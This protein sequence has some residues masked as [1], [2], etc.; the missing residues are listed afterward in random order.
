M[1]HPS[2]LWCCWLQEVL[3][4]AR[5]AAA[6]KREVKKEEGNDA[7]ASGGGWTAGGSEDDSL[8]S[9]AAQLTARHEADANEQAKA[10]EAAGG[11]LQENLG[12]GSG[13]VHP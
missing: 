9:W 1:A 12:A 4:R 7:G 6:I 8:A 3:S 10:D 13:A 11:L 5:R 2:D